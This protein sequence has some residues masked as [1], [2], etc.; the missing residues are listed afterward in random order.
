[1][2]HGGSININRRIGREFGLSAD[3]SLIRTVAACRICCRLWEISPPELIKNLEVCLKLNVAPDAQNPG[4]L[5]LFVIHLWLQ[6]KSASA[7]TK[8]S[9]K[10]GFCGFPWGF[11]GTFCA[12][13][14]GRFF[15]T[16][17]TPPALRYQEQYNLT[18]NK[19]MT[20][21]KGKQ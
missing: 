20:L 19:L 12:F 13:K 11:S 2:E 17:R 10:S 15:L 5:Q 16:R 14:Q 3:F 18:K 9:G 6:W 4:T 8:T 21:P 1:M 7:S